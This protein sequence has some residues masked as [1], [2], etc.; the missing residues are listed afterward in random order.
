M[1]WAGAATLTIRGSSKSTVGKTLERVFL[2][3]G[4]SVL[5]LKEGEDFWL[6]MQRDQEVMREVDAELTS[7]RGRIRI[8]IGLIERGNQ[9]V[10]EDKIT[11]VGRGGIVIFDQIGAR[12][13]A[14]RT[15]EAQQ[16]C[17]I[18]IRNN[19]PLSELYAF[20]KDKVEKEL[21][22]PPMDAEGINSA[23]GELPDR[24]FVE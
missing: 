4:L 6:N 10:I 19:R 5:G 7:R 12:S 8:E 20:L 17:F 1:L 16:V 15:A 18:Q 21:T 9:E 3:V 11:R 13:N 14:R 23:I 22:E 24:L 2:R